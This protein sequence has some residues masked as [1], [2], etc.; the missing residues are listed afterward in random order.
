MISRNVAP[1]QPSHW[2]Q[3]LARAY[4]DPRALLDD[5]K[6]D[7]ALLEL[8]PG[9]PRFPFRV[10]R[11]YAARMR[12]GDP[13]D[14]LL[15]QVL[16]LAAEALATPGF[17]SDPVGDLDAVKQ[18]GLL[19]KYHGRVLLV[20]TGACAIHC[21]YCFRQH[22]PYSDSNPLKGHWGR[23][24]EYIA[25][26]TGIEEVILSGGDPLTLTDQRLATL[27]D[28]LCAIPHIQRLRIHTRLPVV[29]PERVDGGLLDWLGG[30]AVKAVM[31]I[32]ANHPNEID[33]DVRA[34]LMHLRTAGVTLLNQAVLLRGVNDTALALE[35]L[36]TSLF[37]AGVLPYYLHMLDK[38]TGTAHFEVTENDAL[39]LITSLQHRLPGYLVPRLVRESPGAPYK[40]PLPGITPSSSA[41]P[42]PLAV[43]N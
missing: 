5:L 18:P 40:L 43:V 16:A 36:S 19:H 3:T 17:H 39:A 12:V 2:Q 34:A 41:P 37:D 4:T 23:A 21:R 28:A 35:R 42:A 15:R 6:I 22:F 11:G 1:W 13:D 9:A 20:T 29:L 38:T 31:V 32:H 26:D 33:A 10:P 24:L 7:A 14:P 8:Y 27:T 25:A 30:L